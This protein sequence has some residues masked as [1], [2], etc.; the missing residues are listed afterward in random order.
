MAEN[1]TIDD[2]FDMSRIPLKPL[3]YS[4]RANA[5]CNEL[6]V[7]YG[8]KGTYHIFIVHHT[9]NKKYIDLTNMIIEQILPNASINA[10]QF[11]V[12]IEG[13]DDP[14]SLVELINFIYKRF[15]YPD[16]LNGFDPE[17]DAW[18]IFEPTTKN[19]LLQDTSG[20]I[21]L[22]ITTAENIYDR[23]GNSIQDRLDDMTRLGFSIDYLY[24][25]S[26][27]QRSFNFT[28]PFPNYSDMMEVRIGTV[29][30]DRTRYQVVNETDDDGN[31]I[32]GT[33]TFLTDM[34]E[35]GRRIDLV[36][37]FNALAKGDGKYEYMSGGN[38]ANN[39]INIG[40][41]E[42][43]S[44]SFTL[45]DSSSVAT[46]KG[47]YNLYS[48]MINMLTENNDNSYWAI[49][50][51]SAAGTMAIN[52]NTT[53]L[54]S[55]PFFLS[56]TTKSIKS[57]R[58]NLNISYNSGK[59]SINIIGARIYTPDGNNLK[60]GLAANKVVKFIVDPTDA[61]ELKAYVINTNVSGVTTNKYIHTCVDQE[62]TIS[63]AD[64]SY[65]SGDVIQVYR[66]GLK[67]FQ[68][69]DYS[70]DEQ[71]E[72]ITLYVRTEDDERIVFESLSI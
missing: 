55:S 35:K 6:M 2:Q 22:P 67:L 17:R 28:Y 45:P 70:I 66:N 71:N 4:Q 11:T 30:V 62:T 58:F 1:R 10:N 16:D 20:N 23:A 69:L 54:P 42:K 7:D 21:Y 40:K 15:L 29:Y 34:I 14:E 12:T 47:L 65:N 26:A 43:V 60:R 36:F 56:V 52:I 24:A 51:S 63:Y 25:T 64:L 68:D 38:I 3:P 37:M 48:E 59:S 19:I 41:L 18:K 57:S 33:L 61:N 50:T 9:D 46:S 44:D 8:D 31:V 39:T 53:E 72:T 13:V 5:Q 32:G 49:D 27:D